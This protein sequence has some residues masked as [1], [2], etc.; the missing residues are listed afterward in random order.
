[1]IRNLICTMLVL[2]L[3]APAGLAESGDAKPVIGMN[4]AVK[5]RDGYE[6]VSLGTNVFDVIVEAG[7]VPVLL[8]PVESLE[9]ID[10]YVG[11]VDGFVFTGGAD[12]DPAR[13]GEEPHEKTSILIPRR[14]NFD[15]ALME[16][17][18]ESGKPVLGICLGMQEMNVA[19][20]GTLIQDIPTET[21][22]SEI[23][24]GENSGHEVVIDA[25][26]KLG[27]ILG[28]MR[29]PANSAHHQAVEVP[30]KGLKVV[31]KSPEGIVEGIERTDL[32]FALGVQW[33]PEAMSGDPHQRLFAALI[34]AA[35]GARD[36]AGDMAK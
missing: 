6:Y 14:E 35:R 4:L 26:S 31:A 36:G 32:P 25:D 3:L 21:E 30:G 10:R 11:M 13:Y 27:G 5:N 29:F 15:F 19:C 16:A 24:R 34:E 9:D 1:M 17:A 7:G 28:K 18:L 22:T 2:I 12:I 8:P 23:H 20:G 33:H